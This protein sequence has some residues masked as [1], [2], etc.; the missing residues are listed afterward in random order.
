M[1][2]IIALKE[3][4]SFFAAPATWFTVAAL[5]FIFAWFF[6]ARLDAF[7]QVQV[8]LAQLANAPGATLAVATPLFGTIALIMMMLVPIFTMRLLAEER[9]NQTLTLL[10]TAPVSARDIVLGK[11]FGLMLFLLL[12]IATCTLMVLTL[13]LGTRLDLGLLFSNACGLF[14]LTAC[15][16]ALGLY[17]SSLTAQPLV[18]A[19]SS[20]AALFGLWLME[21]SAVDNDHIWHAFSPTTHFQNF[22]VGLLN[23][24]DLVFLLLFCMTFLLLAMRRLRNNSIYG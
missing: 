6:L 17:I 4:R 2:S 18:A 13:M 5:Q 23:S 19:I 14:L 11:F 21:V 8:Q 16:V 24:G 3:F 22:N 20:L 7:L 10:M 15:Y 12:I 9:R 1:I